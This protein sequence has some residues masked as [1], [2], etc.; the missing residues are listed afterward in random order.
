MYKLTF[1]INFIQKNFIP[2]NVK[3]LFR[4]YRREVQLSEVSDI[5]AH[6]F[7]PPI[8]SIKSCSQINY[9]AI[10]T[11]FLEKHKQENYEKLI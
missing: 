1:Y 9:L 8:Q 6:V 10:L 4:R 2:F 3:A 11:S 5:A 7:Q